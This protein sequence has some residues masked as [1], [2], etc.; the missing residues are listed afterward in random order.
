[1]RSVLSKLRVCTIKIHRKESGVALI[2][3]AIIALPFLALILGMLEV[4]LIFWAGYELDN[5]TLA[6]SRMIKTGQAQKNN[7]TQADMITE[8]CNNVAILSDCAS[9]L[10][11]TVQSFSSFNCIANPAQTGCTPPSNY[12]LGGGSQIELVTSSYEW[13]LFN[14]ATV[15]LLSNLPDGNRLIQSAAVFQNEP[16]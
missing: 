1:M 9:K 6:A 14:F 5:A 8:I 13:P 11:L 4:G 15:A 7:Y 2:E 16:F 12:N 10:Q 3:F